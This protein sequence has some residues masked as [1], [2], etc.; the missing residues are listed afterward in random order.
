M[1]SVPERGDIDRMPRGGPDASWLDR[2]L[3]TDRSEYL[4]RDDVDDRVKRR[5]VRS[6][7]RIGRLSNNHEKF[8]LL[9][10]NQVAEVPDPRI[11]ELGAGHGGL[12][13][14]LLELHPRAKVTVTDLDRASVA[15]LVAG[16]LG[17]DPRATIGTMD[18]T[19]IDAPDGH[20]DL[21]VF[22]LGFHHLAPP[23]ASRVF[24]EGTRVA[25]KLMIIDLPRLPSVLHILQLGVFL[26]FAAFHPFAHDGL[27][28]S[29]RAYSPSA[30]RALARHADP[31]IDVRIRTRAWAPQVTI[32]SREIYLA[33]EGASYS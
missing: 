30:M 21:V 17:H 33:G 11:L 25:T 29:L 4:D 13:R 5:I 16:D 3:Q 27:I 10:I 7:E 28:S 9:A 31:T 2:R 23:L 15:D 12:S 18:A 24:T 20:F 8:A 6:L 22:A 19:A 1:T 14:K 26:P 32:A